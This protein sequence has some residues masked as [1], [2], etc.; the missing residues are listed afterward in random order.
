MFSCRMTN[1]RIG[2]AKFCPH[3][4]D[5]AALKL[6]TMAKY[7][8]L[9]WTQNFRGRG[10]SK[11]ERSRS[12]LYLHEDFW[13]KYCLQPHCI[14]WGHFV[15]LSDSVGHGEINTRIRRPGSNFRN[16]LCC[17][18]SDQRTP[19][20]RVFHLGCQTKILTGCLDGQRLSWSGFFP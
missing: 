17:G 12:I 14:A 11:R 19:C 7:L 8:T 13:G 20:L 3:R 1:S 6:S 9:F 2:D 10:T 5:R 18:Y 15:I 16:F 4:L